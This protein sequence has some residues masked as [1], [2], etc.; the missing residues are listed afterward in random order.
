VDRRSATLK[1]EVL[2]DLYYIQ[3]SVILLEVSTLSSSTP[4][5]AESTGQT[6]IKT[7]TL[8]EGELIQDPLATTELVM[9]IA[10]T[11]IFIY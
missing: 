1:D 3:I 7:S 2:H 5:S 8:T 11:F 9:C 6:S 10:H 4:M